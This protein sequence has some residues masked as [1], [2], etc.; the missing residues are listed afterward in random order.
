MKIQT[1]LDSVIAHV[2]ILVGLCTIVWA[3]VFIAQDFKESI[4]LAEQYK[5]DELSAKIDAYEIPID[6]LKELNWSGTKG[7]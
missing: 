2:G 4:Q 5:L 7:Q 6:E 1:T 3:I